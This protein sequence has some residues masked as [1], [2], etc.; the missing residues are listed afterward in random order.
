MKP[1][2]FLAAL[3]AVPVIGMAS[4]TS[5]NGDT[6]SSRQ[7]AI[8]QSGN[9]DAV[10]INGDRSGT[11]LDSMGR[12]VRK[13]DADGVVSEYVYHPQSGKLILVFSNDLRTEFHYDSRGNLVRAENSK[14]LV[15]DLEYGETTL[16]QR[17]VEVDGVNKRRHELTFKYNA[18]G[19]PTVI[20]LA[21]MG[22]IDVEYDE[23]GEI[24]KV[25]SK[26]G[27]RMALQV[28]QIF[29]KLLSVV[30]VAGVRC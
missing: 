15:I 18:A 5:Q 11:E 30:S 21:G 8:E 20:A 10:G 16:I 24:S 1:L 7:V 3:L 6:A 22:K 13:V 29:Q 26:Q 14:D 4:A 23:Q 17:I 2:A 12:I 25:N 27:A 19:R 9:R 28:T